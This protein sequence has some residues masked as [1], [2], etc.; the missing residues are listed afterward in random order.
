MKQSVLP[1][2]IEFLAS[3]SFAYS[4]VDATPRWSPVHFLSPT[5]ISSS[6][7]LPRHN[8]FSGDASYNQLISWLLR[9]EG[10]MSRSQGLSNELLYWADTWFTVRRLLEPFFRWSPFTMIKSFLN[11]WVLLWSIK[12]KNVTLDKR[13]KQLNSRRNRLG[14]M[15]GALLYMA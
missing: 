10:L 14:V 1:Q 7:K 5:C 3:R 11:I 13:A 9:C 2:N 12:Q 4:W 6:I 8:H 15:F